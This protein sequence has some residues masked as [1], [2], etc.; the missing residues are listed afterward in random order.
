MSRTIRLEAD[1]PFPRLNAMALVGMSSAGKTMDEEARLRVVELIASESAAAV[2]PYD[3][4][5]P[6]AFELNMNLVTGQRG[7]CEVWRCGK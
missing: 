1:C 5:L 3:C 2:Q 7:T 6:L 4:G